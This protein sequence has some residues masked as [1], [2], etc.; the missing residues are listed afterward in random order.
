MSKLITT[1]KP[2]TA[3][4]K[5]I[6]VTK[7]QLVMAAVQ[8]YRDRKQEQIDNF[9][10][11]ARRDVLKAEA[12]KIH[13]KLAKLLKAHVRAVTGIKS[14]MLE[15]ELCLRQYKYNSRVEIRTGVIVRLCGTDTTELAQI[16]KA[17]SRELTYPD[18]NPPRPSVVTLEGLGDT[19]DPH[20]VGLLSELLDAKKRLLA[21]TLEYGTLRDSLST[22][23]VT[24]VRQ[25]LK[26]EL[27]SEAQLADI[28][29]ARAL[30]TSTAHCTDIDTA[31][32]G[33]GL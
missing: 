1:T 20:A 15:T 21:L 10:F 32:D 2:V 17:T 13:Q 3:L 25:V 5:D 24:H 19:P 28:Q 16:T 29:V 12:E 27:K 18:A 22:E 31:L 7:S 23:N 6:K 11:E 14:N 8:R 30:V 26:R 33:L 9:D 4:A